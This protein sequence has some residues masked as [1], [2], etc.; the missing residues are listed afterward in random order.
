MTKVNEVSLAASTRCG[1]VSF[2]L[3]C[4][5]AAMKI[6]LMIVILLWAFSSAVTAQASEPEQTPDSIKISEV[7][8]TP[9]VEQ[10][11][12][13]GET[14]GSFNGIKLP[15]IPD[16]LPPDEKA[17]FGSAYAGDLAET[18]AA[19]A[20]GADVNIAD[21]KKR[22]ALMLASSK[23][24]TAV[25]EYL[26][27]EGADVNAKDGDDQTALMYASKRSFNETAAVLLKNGAEVNVQSRKKGVSPLMLAAVWDNVVLVNMLLEHGADA[28]VTDLFGRTAEVLA[29]KKGNSAVVEILSGLPK[30]EANS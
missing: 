20:R 13:P 7:D 23:G 15:K 16:F 5:D 4:Y 14:A 9:D 11:A 30:P 10:E 27:G 25:V 12:E 18:Q 26:I 17:L 29:Q 3:F 6:Q 2:R 8:Q 22:T 24:H 21:Q 28:S 19:L 1:S